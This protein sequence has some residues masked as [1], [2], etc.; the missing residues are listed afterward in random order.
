MSPE[1]KK[2]TYKEMIERGSLK[3]RLMAK[4]TTDSTAWRNGGY[5]D[6]GEEMIRILQHDC[7]PELCSTDTGSV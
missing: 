7:A 4:A 1:A 3:L 2:S 5:K 6:H